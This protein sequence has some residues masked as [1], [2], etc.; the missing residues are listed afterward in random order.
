MGLATQPTAAAFFQTAFSVCFECAGCFL[1]RLRA[2]KAACTFLNFVFRQLPESCLR[3]PIPCSCRLHLL[4]F[5]PQLKK[6]IPPMIS[7]QVIQY[8]CS[9]GKQE[10]IQQHRKVIRFFYFFA[11]KK[12]GNHHINPIRQ[13]HRYIGHQNKNNAG[14][15][16]RKQN[17]NPLQRYYKVR[18]T[19][20]SA[21]VKSKKRRI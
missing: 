13:P 15:N 1:N 9:K 20:V 16:Y 7:M 8:V 14:H 18:K 21:T 11:V 2:L 5:M 10:N 12:V 3:S 4:Q 17:R 19:P 6:A